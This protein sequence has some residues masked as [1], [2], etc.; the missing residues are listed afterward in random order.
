[1]PC[2]VLRNYPHGRIYAYALLAMSKCRDQT[3]VLAPMM[4]L[5]IIYTLSRFGLFVAAGQLARET[6]SKLIKHMQCEG[7]LLLRQPVVV[8]IVRF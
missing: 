4:Q 6:V 2:G 1:V 3:R 8:G 7:M 5:L